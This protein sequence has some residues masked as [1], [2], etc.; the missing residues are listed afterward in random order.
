[1]VGKISIW[2]H[3]SFFVCLFV[4]HLDVISNGQYDCVVGI[5]RLCFSTKG[6]NDWSMYDLNTVW[7]PV[8]T[9]IVESENCG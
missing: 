1:M 5:E 8:M 4:W 7:S 6:L 9:I 3:E 2:K